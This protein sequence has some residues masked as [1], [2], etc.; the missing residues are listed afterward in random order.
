[1]SKHD[2]QLTCKPGTGKKRD[3]L[4][5]TLDIGAQA[6]KHISEPINLLLKRQYHQ[7]RPSLHKWLDLAGLAV[8][9]LTILGLVWLLFPRSTPDLIIVDAAIAPTEVVTG[10]ASTLSF[11][12]ENQSDEPITNAKLIFTFPEHFTLELIE[13]EDA[14]HI[15][16]Q[17]LQLGNI[18]PG[19]YGFIHVTGTMFGDVGGRQ[20]FTTE[21]S[22]SYEDGEKQDTKY[23]EHTFSPTHSTLALEL[24][25]PEHLVAYQ[26]VEGAISYK[27]TG[28]VSFPDMAIEPTWPERFSL[29]SATQHLQ[30]D[31]A[32]HVRGI[33]PGETGTIHF[34]GRLG[35]QDD[36]TFTFAPSFVFDDARYSQEQLIDTIDILPPPLQLSHVIEN[37]ALHPGKNA[38]ITLVYEHTGDHPLSNVR[39]SLSADQDVFSGD[40]MF[41]DIPNTLEPGDTGTLTLT[42]P[43]RSTISRSQLSVYENVTVTTTPVATFTFSPNGERIEVN[44]TGEGF[45]S[46]L[47]SPIT[48]Q[49][50]GRYWTANGDQLGRGPIPPVVGET[51]KYWVFWNVSGTTNELN[52]IVID[53]DLG[54]GVSLTGRQSV[55]YGSSIES[56]NGSVRWS[57]GAVAPTMPSGS[58]VI[59]AAFEVAVTPTQ[60]Q[61]GSIATLLERAYI[62]AQD[63]WTG[64]AIQTSASDVSTN[65]SSD[66]KAAI[67][68]GIVESE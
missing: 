2:P 12:Y 6:G 64:A 20:T 48:F 56:I 67:Y 9:A 11:R 41:T 16:Q 24:T 63:T 39:L 55:S 45:S 53:A 10:G 1:M 40:L 15:N 50:F 23:I 51:T 52:N 59:G 54:P 17:T 22:Y 36:S 47:T 33:E 37:A 27:N 62:S 29:V 44:T 18:S 34:V 26:L 21:L 42:L 58:S 60:D 14:Q 35:T 65:L 57:L 19:Q 8:I 3:L 68:G 13:S 4:V 43:V 66:A 32:F 31:G 30:D 25:L 5:C 28:D 61:A 49:S 38:T 46:P 7:Q